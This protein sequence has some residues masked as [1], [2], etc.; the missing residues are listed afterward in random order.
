MAEAIDVQTTFPSHIRLTSMLVK[1]LSIIRALM[2][3]VNARAIIELA[4]SKLMDELLTD[5]TAP[6][7]LRLRILEVKLMELEAKEASAYKAYKALKRSHSRIY[8]NRDA[9]EGST[10]TDEDRRISQEDPELGDAL[11]GLKAWRSKIAEEIAKTARELKY[12]LE[13][14]A[15]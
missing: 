4:V 2:G 13:E 5:G 9:P 14:D 11:E 7:W 1:K 3:E 12:H 8:L 15:K 6:R 10:R